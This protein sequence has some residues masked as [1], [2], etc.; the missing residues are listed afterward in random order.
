MAIIYF[1]AQLIGATIGY[2]F[3]VALTPVKAL[4]L[5]AGQHGFCQTA[6]HDDLNEAQ[7]FA[8][9]YIATM[10]LIS[11]CCAVWDP[12]NAKH[13]DSIPIKFG[14]TIT[15]LSFIFVSI[16]FFFFFSSFFQG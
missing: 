13:Q 7:A 15:V 4:A 6:P 9:E 1:F 16:F 5:S 3:I 2:R 14:L 11:V 10:V 12:R 8:C